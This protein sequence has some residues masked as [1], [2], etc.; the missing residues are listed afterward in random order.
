MSEEFLLPCCLKLLPVQPR[1]AKAE[2]NA[3]TAWWRIQKVS[4]SLFMH[5]GAYSLC[6]QKEMIQR[7]IIMSFGKTFNIC[8]SSA[9]A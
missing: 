1:V 9:L 8:A 7:R 4:G 5:R 2:K 6:K 3:I